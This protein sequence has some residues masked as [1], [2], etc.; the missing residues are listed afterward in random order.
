MIPLYPEAAVGTVG[1]MPDPCLFCAGTSTATN[2][3]V[4]SQRISQRVNEISPFTAQHGAPVPRAANASRYYMS[5]IID[6]K[7]RAACRDCN[8]VFFNELEAPC[9]PFLDHAMADKQWTLD[10]DIK[11]HVAAWAY[12]TAL[13]LQLHTIPRKTWPASI[14]DQCHDLHTRRHPPVGVRVWA[15]RYDLTD[16]FP[17]MVHGGRFSELSFRRRGVEYEGSQIIFT[18]CYALFIVVFWHGAAPDD[19][20]L[21]R[22]RIAAEAII[23]IWPALVGPVPWPPPVTVSYADL[24]AL[25]IFKSANW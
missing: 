6:I 22:Q 17:D 19:F 12:K 14:L 18:L 4:I 7:L 9:Q 1:W 24:D 16:S 25:A 11:R 13:L 5:R 3:H 2:E 15:G 8:G 21:E 20:T 10:V 23:P